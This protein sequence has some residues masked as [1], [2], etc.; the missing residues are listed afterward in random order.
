MGIIALELI[1]FQTMFQEEK[2]NPL[3]FS[4]TDE[5]EYKPDVYVD[6]YLFF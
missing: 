1:P 6:P 2:F 5:A 3:K 4:L